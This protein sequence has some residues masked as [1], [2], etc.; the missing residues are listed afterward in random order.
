M[1]RLAGLFAAGLAVSLAAVAQSAEPLRLT[2]TIPLP[3]VSGRLDHLAIDLKGHRLFVA[4]LENNTVEV[5]DLKASKWVRSV[6]GFSKPQGVFYAPDIK[7][8]FVA[9]GADGTCK[10]LDGRTLEVTGTENL[11]QGADLV[12][13]DAHSKQLYV[14]HGGKDAGNDHG[15][16]ALIDAITGKRVFR[17]QTEAHPGA[18]L[19][20][21][22]PQVFVVIPEKSHV[23]VLD[24]KTHAIIQTWTVAG[25]ARTVSLALDEAAHRLFVGTR[26]PPAIVVLDSESGKEVAR[27][28]TVNTLDGIYFDRV[29]RRIYAS[30]GEGFVDVERQIDADHYESMA[31]VPTGPTARTSLFVPELKRLFVAVPVAPD[32][33]A[34][35][36]VFEVRP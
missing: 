2:Q 23:L 8:L 11:S 1:L 3:E 35:I 22:S 4:A 34:E 17:V 14:G 36:L 10:A 28:P 27:M 26:N 33:A 21:D 15:E 30:G 32:R 19:V 9:S 31:H 16:L 20:N 5:I 7:K 6:A 29:A 13:Y 24:R 18:I 25:G 12:D